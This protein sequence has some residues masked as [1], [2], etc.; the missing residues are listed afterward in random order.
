MGTENEEWGKVSP[1]TAA[2]MSSSQV[3]LFPFSPVS[4]QWV[5]IRF[6]FTIRFCFAI[7]CNALQIGV[8]VMECKPNHCSQPRSKSC[9]TAQPGKRTKDETNAT[10]FLCGGKAYCPAIGGRGKGDSGT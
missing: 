7:R 2:R 5:A 8:G 3:T 10:S 9:Q 4:L 1:G 6:C